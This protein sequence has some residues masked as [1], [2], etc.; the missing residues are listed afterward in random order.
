MGLVVVIQ[1][2]YCCEPSNL[3]PHQCGNPNLYIAVNL[4]TYGHINVVGAFKDRSDIYFNWLLQIKLRYLCQ[5]IWSNCFE[6]YPSLAQIT[7]LIS[8][9]TMQSTGEDG[10][11]VVDYFTFSSS[12]ADNLR[13]AS[14]VI[15]HAGKLLVSVILFAIILTQDI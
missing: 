9:V 11:L 7:L 14:L 15:S 2:L 8:F 13:S 5:E 4:Q 12:I 6:S 1:S 10:S 3:W